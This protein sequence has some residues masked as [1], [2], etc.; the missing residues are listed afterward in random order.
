MMSSDYERGEIIYVNL[1][2]PGKD[3]IGH[4]QAYMRPCVVIK[5]LSR[6]ELVI[7]VP[8]TSPSRNI[9]TTIVDCSK[10]PYN[11]GKLSFALCHQIR[12]VSAK[13]VVK[14]LGAL[15]DTHFEK[16]LTVIADMLEL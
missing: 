7:I 3:I 12:T 13:R 16:I 4:E 11:Q 14:T 5:S 15:D 9:S 1:G 2:T 6:L 8:L 10:A